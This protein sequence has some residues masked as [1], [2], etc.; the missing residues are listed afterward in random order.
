[1][2]PE[3]PKKG[4]DEDSVWLI[5]FLSVT[6]RVIASISVLN[7]IKILNSSLETEEHT[8]E[9]PQNTPKWQRPIIFLV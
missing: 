3:I 9:G 4:P 8:K 5:F 1:M 7:F 2:G 6:A